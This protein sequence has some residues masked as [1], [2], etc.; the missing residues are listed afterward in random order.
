MLSSCVFIEAHPR[1]PTFASTK[2]FPV[3][4]FADP[5]PLNPYATILYKKG[6]GRGASATATPTLSRCSLSRLD[7]TL[8]HLFA[9]VAN[10]RLTARLSSL[11]ATLIENRGVGVFFPFWNESARAQLGSPQLT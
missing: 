8:M 9:S 1:L 6:G 11:D 5:H 7:A 2:S 10:K 4:S 3:I